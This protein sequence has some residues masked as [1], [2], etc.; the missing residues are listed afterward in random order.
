MIQEVPIPEEDGAQSGRSIQ[1]G[2]GK[3]AVTPNATALTIRTVV[4]SVGVERSSVVGRTVAGNAGT[5]LFAAAIHHHVSRTTTI[6][7]SCEQ[8]CPYPAH[9]TSS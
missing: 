8:L 3:L 9:C 7:G 4:T 6:S 5:E 2:H 1:L